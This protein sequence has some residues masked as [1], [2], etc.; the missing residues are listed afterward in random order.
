[1][2]NRQEVLNKVQTMVFSGKD[3]M[4]I[5]ED[6]TDFVLGFG[7]KR[8]E[9]MSAEYMKEVTEFVN[10]WIN[11]YP[12]G[13]K[14]GTKLARGDKKMCVKKMAKFLKDYPEFTKDD[15][16]EATKRYLRER[17]AEDWA[18]LSMASNFIHHQDKGSD[19]A[20]RCA[21][22]ETMREAGVEREIPVNSGVVK[23]FFL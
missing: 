23:E 6:L 12:A 5:S 7:K 10:K 16:M 20:A 15:V 19:L 9:V 14:A 13:V 17:E 8:K 3:P 11:L 21:E 22:M 4:E 18:Y 2:M 1:M